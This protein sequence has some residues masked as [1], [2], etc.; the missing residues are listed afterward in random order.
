MLYLSRIRVFLIAI[1]VLLWVFVPRASFGQ[2][3]YGSIAGTVTDATGSVIQGANVTLT[4]LETAETHTMLTAGSG[5]YTFVNILPGRYK[6]EV[7]K[8]GFKKII[9]QPIIVEIESGLRVDL[10]LEV[11]AVNQTVEVTSQAPLLQ[12][13]TSSLG[14][15]VETRTVT[16]LPLNGRNPLALVALTAGVVPQGQPS[17]GNSSTGN[18]VGAN[19]FAAGDFQIGGGQAGQSEIL[20]D[21]VPTNGAYLNVVTVI[22][23]QDAIQEF[24]VQTNNLGPEYG[25]FAG[26]VINLSTK[27]GTNQFHGSLYEFI[28]NK[29]LNANDF[30]SNAAGNPRPAFTQNQFGVNGGGPAIKDKLFFFSTYEGFRQRKGN[31]L[32]TWV[33]TAAERNGNFSG[34]GSTGTAAALP[35]YD[36]LTSANC[37]SGVA[38]CRTQFMYNGVANVIPPNRLDPTA[39]T[40]LSYFPL[41]N[42]F[43]NP[44]GNFVENYPT[45]GNV[46]QINERADWNINQNQRIFARYTR[47]HVLSLPDSQ[48]NDICSD[49]CTENTVTNQAGFG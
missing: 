36:P 47:S 46:N 3:V 18:P 15:V 29:V 35:I 48:F 7:E 5:E 8:T 31:V 34:V 39:Q 23:T 16:E 42:S 24:K 10:A 37:V 13:E 21:G 40:L 12:P 14:Q 1:A 44:S 41:P 26:G 33:P 25:R 49:R 38:A 6:I 43:G 32:T 30:F 11:G 9:R 19:P 20:I 45:G 17:A 22:P 28:R 4:N 27:S 2:N